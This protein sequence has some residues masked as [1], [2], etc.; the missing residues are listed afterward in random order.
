MTEVFQPHSSIAAADVTEYLHTPFQ[1]SPPIEPFTSAEIIE[2]IS[3]LNPKKAAGHDLIGN[4]AIKE[5]PIKGI[6]LITSIFNATLRLEHFPKAWNISLITLI[7]KPGKPI[8]ETSSYR[9]IS[10]LPTL[11]KLF[12]RML[13]N[14]LL[15]LLEELKTLPDHQFG[16]QKQHS[17][18]EQIHR[19]THIISQTLEKKK[20]CSAVFL[21]IQQAFDKVWHEGLLYKLKKLLPHTYYSILK[22]YLTNRQF[23][24]KY[25]DAITTTFPMEA[26]IP[27]GRVLGPLLFSIYTADL[28]ISNEITI[29][30]FADDTAL[31][32]THADPAIA[33]STLQRCLDSMEKWFQKWGFKI[34]EKKSS[35]V[36]F[37]FRKQTCPQ[38]TI[39]NTIIPSKDSVR[40]LGMTLEKR[41]I[42]KKHISEKTKQL[43][44]KL[45]KF[46]WLT[47]RRSK[48]NIQ[49]KITLY[50]A[51][52]KPV[53]TY[54]IQLWETASNSN[55]EILQRFQSKTLRSLLNAPWYVTNETIHRDLKI[56]TVKDEIHKSR[57]RYNTRVKNHHNPLV[58]QLLD[59]TDQIRRLK[60]KYPLD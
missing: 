1:M 8:Y 55:I 5:L 38:V 47:G 42:W 58:I 48:L 56:P 6:A 41:L 19:I 33:S 45:R 21:D 9:P 14:R 50:K 10:L 11:S 29:A 4:K 7:P 17:T 43:K 26:G 54:G 15:L 12:E 20:Y 44:E 3:R 40:Y 36:T 46:Y 49:N 27:Q 59:T 37:T 2:A 32:A 23:M 52:I 35:H 57:S 18:V 13:T 28:P 31:L 51:V 34:N 60:I 24:V 22:S 39:N 53:W 25:A 16:F 30:T